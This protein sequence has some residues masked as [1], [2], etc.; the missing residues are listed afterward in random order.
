MTIFITVAFLAIVAFGTL[1]VSM[2]KLGP[3]D[4]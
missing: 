1:P 4:R 3:F 2:P